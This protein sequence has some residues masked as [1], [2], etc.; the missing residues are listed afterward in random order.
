VCI[1]QGLEDYVVGVKHG[2]RIY[3]ALSSLP[4]EKKEM[5]LLPGVGH[6]PAIEAPDTLTALLR[7]FFAKYPIEE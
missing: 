5:H 6:S 2:R 4:L 7:D 1:I 3:K